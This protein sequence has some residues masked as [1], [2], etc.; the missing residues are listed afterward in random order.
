MEVYKLYRN[1]KLNSNRGCIWEVSNYG[2][3]KKNGE[4]YTPF[5]SGSGY[6]TFGHRMYIHRAVAEL[7]INKIPKGYEVDHIDGNK[8]NNNVNNL[9]IV[10]HY[11]NMKNR[12]YSHSHETIEK[13]R[14]SNIGHHVS[15]EQRIKQSKS[16][17]GKLS[18]DKNPSYGKHWKIVNG[19]REYY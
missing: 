2:N 11:E 7:F 14:L 18:G 1:T 4:L 8:Y 3:V 17:K 19:K 10:T 13:I 12:N 9:R 6:L 16:M 5:T 15:K